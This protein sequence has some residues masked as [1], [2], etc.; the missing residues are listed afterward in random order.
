MWMR[1]TL[2]VSIAPPSTTVTSAAVSS[3]E[4]LHLEAQTRMAPE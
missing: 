2:G 4:P 3:R 1:A